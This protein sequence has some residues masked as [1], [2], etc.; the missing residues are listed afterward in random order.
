M[1]RNN[2]CR[3]PRNNH[4]RNRYAAKGSLHEWDVP[5]LLPR[6]VKSI[7]TALM[8]N[9]HIRR[10]LM[11]RTPWNNDF[12]RLINLMANFTYPEIGYFYQSKNG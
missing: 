3:T 12:G 4:I 9:M 5:D 2:H 7:D 6:A 11:S 1:G 8:P 10:R